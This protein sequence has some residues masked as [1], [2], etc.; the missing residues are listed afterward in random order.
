MVK[1]KNIFRKYNYDDDEIKQ[2]LFLNILY[3][4]S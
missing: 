3:W 2:L 1:R 4:L